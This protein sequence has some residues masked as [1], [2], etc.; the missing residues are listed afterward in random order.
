MRERFIVCDEFEGHRFDAVLTHFLK[1]LSR[2]QIKPLIEEGNAL[3][4]NQPSSPKTKVRIGQELSADITAILSSRTIEDLPEDIP[5]NIVFSDENLLVINKP[6]GL[7]VHPGSGQA[8]GTLLNA[9]LHYDAQLSQL[10]RAG[11]VHRLDKMT[12]GLMV[13]ARD[14]NA[15]IFLIDQLKEHKVRR[16]YKALVRGNPISGGSVDKPIGRHP[17]ARKKMAVRV[18]GGKR[19]VTHYRILQRFKGYTLIEATLETGRTHQIRVHM[20]HLGFPIVGDAVYARRMALPAGLTEQTISAVLG[21]KRQALHA[22]KLELQ[23]PITGKKKLW[24]AALPEDMQDLVSAMTTAGDT[25]INNHDFF[26]SS[27]YFDSFEENQDSE[28]FDEDEEV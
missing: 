11:I 17:K 8:K 16:V 1:P 7:V 25:Y 13:V 10:P 6:V 3:L 19:A 9:L 27:A 12:S 22:S 20:A 15:R 26:E 4:D 24:K 23:H 28:V 2:S 14:E 18:T 21:F 5:L